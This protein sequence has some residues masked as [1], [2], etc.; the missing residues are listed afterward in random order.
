MRL[1]KELGSSKLDSAGGTVCLPPSFPPRSLEVFDSRLADAGRDGTFNVVGTKL[2]SES[3]S[4][5]RSRFSFKHTCNGISDKVRSFIHLH[6]AASLAN[7]LQLV[8][9]LLPDVRE[10]P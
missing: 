4:C 3:R 10:S 7:M 5:W 6:T 8:Y 9:R 2:T 1:N